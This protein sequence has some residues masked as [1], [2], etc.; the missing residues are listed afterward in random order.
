[1]LSKTND[2]LAFFKN[3]VRTM[4][5][6]NFQLETVKERWPKYK[7]HIADLYYKDAKFRTICE[8]YYLC[9]QYLEKFK[10]E[11]SERL[12]TIEEYK[13]IQQELEKELQ[14]RIE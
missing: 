3:S 4:E 11:F 14:D 5:A 8:D 7:D 2:L 13:K 6:R 9:I 10:K 1:M 12:E